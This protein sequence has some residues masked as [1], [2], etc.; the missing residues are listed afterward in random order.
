MQRID[1]NLVTFQTNFLQSDSFKKMDKKYPLANLSQLATSIIQNYPKNAELSETKVMKMLD[2]KRDEY[3]DA[4]NIVKTLSD[5]GYTAYFAGGWVRDHVLGYPSHDIDIVTNASPEE[6][7]RLFPKTNPVGISFGVVN[8]VTGE[9]EFQVA[10]FR[11]DGDYSD[12]RHPT[13]IEPA[14]PMEDAKRRDFTINGMF[15]DPLNDKVIDFVGGR[16][17]IDN[18]IIQTIGNPYDRFKEDRLRMLRAVRFAARLGFAIEESTRSAIKEHASTLVPAVSMDK[19]W[20]E[21]TKMAAG[22]GFGTAIMMMHEFG[23]LPVIFPQLKDLPLEILQKRVDRFAQFPE[24]CPLILFISEL[25]E[26]T[27]LTEMKALCEYLKVSKKEV[28][29]VE[30]VLQGREQINKQDDWSWAH[31]FAKPNSQMALDVIFAD[32]P[33]ERQKYLKLA[34]KL[35]NHISRIERKAPLMTAEILKR[36]GVVPGKL[37]G[38][39]LKE[40]EKIAINSNFDD[41]W[42]VLDVLKASPLWKKNDK[43]AASACETLLASS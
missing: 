8:V 21:L 28:Q 11:K 31:Y 4:I 29:M 32:K 2:I 40:A 10:T 9:R 27:N 12:G 42:Q 38:E 13:H 36:E 23:L 15:Y 16:T 39:L 41:P 43:P 24:N 34:Q 6:M 25:V 14:D 20:Q 5:A 18:K 22:P 26:V 33:E 37:M 35:K 7:I 3:T 19:I 30:L 17:G 1:S